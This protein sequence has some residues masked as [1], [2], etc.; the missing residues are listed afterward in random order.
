M[1]LRFQNPMQEKTHEI[2]DDDLPPSPKKILIL[3]DDANL[4]LLLRELLEAHSY[5][6]ASVTTGV[7]GIKKIMNEN[8]DVIICD[9]VMPSMPGDMFYKAVERTKPSLCQR[10]IFMTGHKGNPKID[11]FIRS[12]KGLM[13]WKPFEMHTLLEAA[14]G[15]IKKTSP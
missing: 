4:V 15:V 9:M 14:A 6:V 1:N 12:V 2:S 13:L 7:E 3:D 10:F 8:F 11:E 5:Q